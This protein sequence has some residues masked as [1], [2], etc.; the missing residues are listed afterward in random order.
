MAELAS[1][2]TRLLKNSKFVW[3]RECEVA[4]E[5]IKQNITSPPILIYPDFSKPFRATT[6][7]SNE[8]LGAVLSQLR[9]DRDHPI[10]FASRTLGATEHSSLGSGISYQST[11]LTS[12]ISRARPI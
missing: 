3:S 5:K 2:I 12:R 1:P 11:I 6:D 9:D 4:L 7:A 8:A 10:A